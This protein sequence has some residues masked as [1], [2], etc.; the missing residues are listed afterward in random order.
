L[1]VGLAVLLLAGAAVGGVFWL[2][3]QPR[4]RKSSIGKP[5]FS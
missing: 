1:L 4:R 3:R 5:R 2:D